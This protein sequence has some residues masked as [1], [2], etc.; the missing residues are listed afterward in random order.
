MEQAIQEMSRH[1]EITDRTMTSLGE[2]LTM[3]QALAMVPNFDGQNMPLRSFLQDVEQALQLV[4]EEQKPAFITKVRTKL[5]DTARDALEDKEIK[6]YPQYCA[7]IQAVRL[8]QNESLLSYYTRIKRICTSAMAS[9][10]ESFNNEN[11]LSGMKK[12]LNGLALES[13]KRGLPDDL[14]YGVSVQNPATLDDAYKI[15][16][17]LEEDLKGSSHRNSNYLAYAAIQP[18]NTDLSRKTRMVNFEDEDRRDAIPFR[19]FRDD[20]Y[21]PSSPRNKSPIRSSSPNY[22]RRI[23]SPLRSRSISP[24]QPVPY[25]TMPGYFPHMPYL[26]SIP[27]QYPPREMYSPPVNYNFPYQ[28]FF[29]G[30]NN[31][32]PNYNS[33]PTYNPNYNPTNNYNRPNNGYDNNYNNSNRN[34]GNSQSPV[35]NKDHLNSDPICQKDALTNQ[36]EKRPSMVRFL[37]IEQ[38]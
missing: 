7:D 24:R 35:P 25:F 32:P 2:N 29:N 37:T 13:F 8:K 21:R 3:T 10:R 27:Y 15:A 20:G 17:R 6:S 33:Y 38:M 16:L 14:I 11:E 34:N 22:E 4:T 12:M 28:P 9:L 19:F 23:G 1:F 5:K 26:P 31:N 30:Q 18:N 36:T